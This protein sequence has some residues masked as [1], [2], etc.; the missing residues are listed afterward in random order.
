MDI[1]IILIKKLL[2]L[3]L[4]KEQKIF[5]SEECNKKNLNIYNNLY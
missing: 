2:V 5:F 3:M 4:E 1:R